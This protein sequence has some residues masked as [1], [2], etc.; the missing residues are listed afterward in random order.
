MLRAHHNQF[1]NNASH[2]RRSCGAA[3][4]LAGAVAAMVGCEGAGPKAVAP[5]PGGTWDVV[6]ATPQVE[7]QTAGYG[8]GGEYSRRDVALAVGPAGDPY[9]LNAWP[10]PAQPS[11]SST[12]FIQVPR[13]ADSTLVFRSRYLPYGAYSGGR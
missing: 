8:A 10:V 3:L 2:Y 5:A 6:F 7:S 12:R 1:L 11:A 4:I 13:N 9:P